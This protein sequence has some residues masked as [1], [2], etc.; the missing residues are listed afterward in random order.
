MS[1]AVI[2]T[3]ECNFWSVACVGN[4]MNAFRILM[5]EPKRKRC[6]KHLGIDGKVVLMR[7]KGNGY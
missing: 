1:F 5:G 4:L 3:R 6:Y 2:R 7:S